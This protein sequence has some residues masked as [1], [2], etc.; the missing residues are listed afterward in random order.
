MRDRLVKTS[1]GWKIWER[2]IGGSTTNS[3]LSP[4]DTKAESFTKYMPQL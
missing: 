1:E 4:P 3:R 2:Y